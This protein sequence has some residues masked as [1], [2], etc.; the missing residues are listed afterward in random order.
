[1]PTS[2]PPASI[3][4]LWILGAAVLIACASCAAGSPQGGEPDA[5]VQP[6][7]DGNIHFTDGPHP[8]DGPGP[9]ADGPAI[10][11][12][13]SGA[14]PD[15]VAPDTATPKPADADKDGH[16]APG[17]PDP[18]GICKS[19]GD[20]DDNDGSRYPG[21]L[22]SCANVGVD[23]D[24][25]KDAAE[26]DLNGDGIDDLGQA[27]S[28]GLPG[29]CAAG[30]QQCDS[31][32]LTCVATIKVGQQVE[33]CNGKDDDCDGKQDDGNLCQNG[34]TCQGAS[35]CRCGSGPACT[36]TSQ[37][38]SSGCTTLATDSKNCGACGVSCG[39]GETCDGG[40]CR[41]GTTL[42]PLAGGPACTSGSCQGGTCLVCN[43]SVNLA[44]QATASSSGGGVTSKGYG[45]EQM[46]NGLLQSS[47][48][49]HWITATSTPGGKWI[50]YSWSAPVTINYVWVDTVPPTA[51]CSAVSGR[52]LAG[53]TLQY[54]NGST[55]V[56]LAGISGKTG[57]WSHS[58][59]TVT[60]TKLRL[61]N[62][63]AINSGY[64]QNPIIFEWQ[65]YCK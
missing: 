12:D 64:A 55:W 3:V 13:G 18:G 25:D 24:C 63:V 45:P 30:T 49:F 38:C 52:T 6:P 4:P 35:G 16:C 21:A 40:R 14:D 47:C 65:V 2:S 59:T 33:T 50:Q 60:T 39:T 20:C 1:M 36:G 41:C 15:A 22:E 17:T 10:P 57:D 19:F 51:T 56:S 9:T 29:V 26:V 7:G 5:K 43:P 61:Y 27:C 8:G 32:L 48:K 58:F 34:N 11:H 42:G 46:N 37:C 44:T 54:W 28:S 31:G 53:G 23:N 62:A